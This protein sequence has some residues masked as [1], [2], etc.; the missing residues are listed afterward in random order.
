M[1]LHGGGTVGGPSDV[2]GGQRA[3]DIISV[4]NRGRDDSRTLLGI[5]TSSLPHVIQHIS[6]PCDQQEVGNIA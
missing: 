4:T 3:W 1:I 5:P 6:H 2:E